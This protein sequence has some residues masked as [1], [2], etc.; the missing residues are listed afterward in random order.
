MTGSA[1]VLYIYFERIFFSVCISNKILE[2]LYTNCRWLFF[3]YWGHIL[4]VG[5]Y[6]LVNR[7]SWLKL[8]V[9]AIFFIEGVYF[10]LKLV[11]IGWSGLKLIECVFVWWVKVDQNS[12]KWVEVS[13]SGLKL[14]K[15]GIF[16]IEVREVDWCGL[17]WVELVNL[18]ILKK[19]T[20]LE[21]M[22]I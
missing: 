10:L 4:F 5:K 13:W 20:T 15:V 21:H 11:K 2:V 22:C 7:W 8:I 6:G 1:N 17:M 12:E 19:R 18:N 14:I 3:V 16:F 9:V